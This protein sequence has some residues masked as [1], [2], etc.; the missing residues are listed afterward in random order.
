MKLKMAKAD[1]KNSVPG[2]NNDPPW[3]AQAPAKVNLF[4]RLLGRRPDGYHELETVLHTVDLADTVE[5][6]PAQSTCVLG[7]GAS[8]PSG[9]D[10]LAVKAL[11]LMQ[12]RF[13]GLGEYAIRLEKII[14]AGG[15]LGGGS[16]DAITTMK[17]LARHVLN[18]D[19]ERLRREL[20]PL[21]AALGSDTVFF[22]HGGTALCTG[23]GERVQSIPHRQLFFNLILPS[24]P[25][26]TAEVY[27]ACR[28]GDWQAQPA[29]IWIAPWSQ[30]GLSRPQ[31][32]LEP[33]CVRA[34]PA[35]DALITRLRASG[36]PICLSGSGSTLFTVHEKLEDQEACHSRLAPFLSKDEKLVPVCSLDFPNS[37][38]NAVDAQGC[39]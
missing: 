22:L 4:L 29:G 15:G 6:S 39:S 23:R 17:L 18:L 20:T 1:F 21:A 19:D 8:I 27:R 35:M 32:D 13:P 38:E 12:Q 5:I 26:A 36:T 24:F 30:S 33:A 16:S 25:C 3:R 34:Y 28:P 10:N 14:P 7:A 11:R 37:S 2:N 9:E 31:N